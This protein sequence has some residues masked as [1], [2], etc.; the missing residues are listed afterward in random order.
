MRDYLTAKHKIQSNGWFRQ[1]RKIA[2]V[3]FGSQT[4]LV[5]DAAQAPGPARRIEII[6]FTRRPDPEPGRRV[7]TTFAV[8]KDSR[9][10]KP[11]PVPLREERPMNWD[12]VKGNWKQFKGNVQQAWGDLTD[13]DVDRIEGKREELVGKIQERTDRP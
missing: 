11:C 3:G 6:L 12:Q 13:D 5:P 1:D 4:P 9:I 8:M 7:G 2:A 10:F